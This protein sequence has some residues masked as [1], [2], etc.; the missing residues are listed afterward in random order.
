MSHEWIDDQTR[1]V[2]VDF[3]TYNPSYNIVAQVHITVEF[4]ATGYVHRMVE[5]LTT[6][7]VCNRINPSRMIE[8]VTQL[9]QANPDPR[10]NYF[11]CRLMLHSVL[12]LRCAVWPF[13]A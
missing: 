13:W 12:I 9:E 3:A 11:N 2:F 4:A 6:D 1:V 5:V 10:S 7:H 8:I